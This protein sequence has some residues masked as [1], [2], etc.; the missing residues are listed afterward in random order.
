MRMLRVPP[1]APARP[2]LPQRAAAPQRPA[3]PRHALLR[4]VP[5]EAPVETSAPQGAAPPRPAAVD[6][7]STPHGHVQSWFTLVG[8]SMLRKS[9]NGAALVG[10]LA[11]PRPDTGA[12]L[13]EL[14]FAIAERLHGLQTSWWQ[15]W[16]TWV[17]EFGKLRRADTM[18]ELM[19]QQWNLLEQFAAQLKAQ[20]L[21]VVEL[22]DQVEVGC[23]YWVAQTLRGG[24]SA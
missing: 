9:G 11:A 10:L 20:A 13:L 8:E 16:A 3:S 5:S 23:G 21:D 4:A 12:E 19:E 15:G 1:S 6:V 17:E 18:S 24:R 7:R 22:Q 14:Q 2:T